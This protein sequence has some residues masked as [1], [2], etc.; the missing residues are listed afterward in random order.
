MKILRK[1]I[2]KKSASEIGTISSRA[3]PSGI[4]SNFNM[5]QGSKTDFTHLASLKTLNT[6][7]SQKKGVFDENRQKKVVTAD[8]FKPFSSEDLGRADENIGVFSASL[9]QS[10]ETNSLCS[11]Q[12]F[13]RGMTHQ[14]MDGARFKAAKRGKLVMK[15][16][17]GGNSQGGTK[18]GP[19]KGLKKVQPNSINCGQS[20]NEFDQNQSSNGG[21]M[22]DI[23]GSIAVNQTAISNQ[24]KL[25]NLTAEQRKKAPIKSSQNSGLGL[26]KGQ[27]LHMK[28]KKLTQDGSAT[29]SRNES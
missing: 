13:G 5:S 3:A 12:S 1:G 2:S 16:K 21:L 26:L 17:K 11:R 15:S 20:F 18:V 19:K 23:F 29:G 8:I 14:S 28:H 6:A 4:S 24:S 27:N 7:E 25:H 22:S 9:S 10:A